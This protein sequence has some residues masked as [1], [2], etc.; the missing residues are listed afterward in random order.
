MSLSYD[1]CLED[2]REDYQN[3]SMLYCV[4]QLYRIIS[5]AYMSSSDMCTRACRLGLDISLGVFCVFFLPKA[6]LL[7]LCLWCIFSHLFWV[8]STIASDCLERLVSKIL[9]K[10]PYYCV[11][12]DVKLLAHSRSKMSK[13]RKLPCRLWMIS[14]T[15]SMSV[16]WL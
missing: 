8:A 1:D 10:W 13:C 16:C 9:I 5:H 11:E 12:R 6:N 3:C 7:V 14:W 4:P 15:Q 2:K